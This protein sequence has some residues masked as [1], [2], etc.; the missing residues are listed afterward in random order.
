M[1]LKTVN[2]VKY[3]QSHPCGGVLLKGTGGKVLTPAPPLP[4]ADDASKW[5]ENQRGLGGEA[6]LGSRK[7]IL[8]YL[9][10]DSLEVLYKILHLIKYMQ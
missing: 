5:L 1:E 2:L 10:I 4:L 8:Q 3:F 9:Y 6:W 7:R